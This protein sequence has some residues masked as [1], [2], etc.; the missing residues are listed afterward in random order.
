MS[1]QGID[2]GLTILPWFPANLTIRE[3]VREIHLKE[4][5]MSLPFTARYGILLMHGAL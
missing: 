1:R 2:D 5:V 4:H 3:K